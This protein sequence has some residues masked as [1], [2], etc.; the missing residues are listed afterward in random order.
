MFDAAALGSDVGLCL[1]PLAAAAKIVDYGLSAKQKVLNQEIA[2][3]VARAHD[4]RLEG[5][6]GTHGGIIGALAGIGLYEHG[7]DGRYIWLKQMRELTGT[8]QTVAALLAA[9]GLEDIMEL[10][11][12]SVAAQAQARIALGEWARPVRVGGR[13]V[14]P[15]EKCTDG[16]ADYRVPDKR[17]IKAFRP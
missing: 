6:T 4:I 3:E 5:L 14:L 2:R 11:G 12:D 10:D 7:D 15:V 16:S 13:A 9:T 17:R 1:A 8:T